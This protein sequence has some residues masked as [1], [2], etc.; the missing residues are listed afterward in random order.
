MSY[1]NDPREMTR[2]PETGVMLEQ[3]NR[4]E[5]TYQWGAM[6]IDLCDLP[7]EEY[8]K[9]MTVIG[10]GGG[11][12][13]ESGETLYTLKFKVDN[14]EVEFKLKSGD[15]IPFDVNAEK[16]GRNFLGWYYG[17][18]EYKDGDLMP[19]RNLVLTAK[20]S[21]N[22]SFVFNIDG[23][24]EQVSAYTVSYNT[25][26]TKIPSTDKPGFEFKGW[27]PSTATSITQHTIFKATFESITYIVTWEGYTDGIISQE[28]KYG[29]TLIEPVA[30]EKEGYTFNG[31][32]KN[33]PQ[34]VTSN[35]SFVA[36]FNINKYTITY[37][38]VI[39]GIE[40]EALST[41]TL[42]YG[43]NIIIKDKPSKDGYN[44]GEWIGYNVETGEV[45]NGNIVPA[46]NIKYLSVRTTLSYLLAYYDNNEKVYDDLI[47]YKE[48]IVPYNYTKEGWTVGEWN[49]LPEDLLMPHYNLS[50]YCESKINSYEVKFIDQNSNEYIVI[51]EY[52]T[53][54]KNIIPLIEGKTFEL[55]EEFSDKLVDIDNNTVTGVVTVNNYKVIINL[56]GSI[57]E[58]E[59]PYETNIREYVEENYTAEEGYTIEIETNNEI[60]PANNSTVVKI[61]YNVNIWTLFYQTSGANEFDTNGQIE[62]AFGQPIIDKLPD[63]NVEGY[64][65]NGWFNK[66]Q[67][68]TSSDL[69]PNNDLHVIGKYSVKKY[70][71]IVKDDENIVLNKQYDYGTKLSNVLNDELVI[72]YISN[73]N[74][75]GYDA[76]LKLNG[77]DVNQ[78]DLIIND[79]EII[80]EKTEKE[81]I[82]SFMNGDVL[83]S[84]ASVKFNSVINY[85]EMNDYTENG[86]EYV[87]SWEDESYN[88]KLM[89][90]MNLTIKGQYQEKADAPIYYGIFVTSSTT[91]DSRIF[92]MDELNTNFKTVK[93]LDCV[94][95]EDIVIEMT[96]DSYL[97]G[98]EADS[99]TDDEFEAYQ[100]IHLYPHCFLIPINIDNTY[101]LMVISKADNKEKI[102]VSDNVELNINGNKYYMYTYLNPNSMKAQ[103][104]DQNWKYKIT[105]K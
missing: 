58:L 77:E 94:D 38:E 49:G 82:L 55:N 69:M 13:P 98:P 37:H 48:K 91:A 57:S 79:I 72:N 27:E 30:P 47:L 9:P 34:V 17:N 68:I 7:V 14:E 25:K 10:L 99:M 89:P 90:A 3:D 11:N 31:W 65:F 61:T 40:S 100:N 88:G 32:D 66:E 16:E 74:S 78:N 15:L 1:I 43:S 101:D 97:I 6:I 93:P 52:K 33:I 87:F 63:T 45:F 85:P 39:N 35:I 26:I 22:I 21:C 44:Y 18:T 70:S 59:L 42:T 19:S 12:I 56:N 83:I 53:P 41:L 71:V 4:R 67:L 24:E 81:Y 23:V 76:V 50:A 28:Y 95:G 104:F 86:I 36:I 60:V 5:E 102:F 84:S 105:L 73:L 75:L 20:Y 80:I 8:M 64:N 2:H 29:D 54:I 92:N 62:V 46:F 103:D 96:A 51:A